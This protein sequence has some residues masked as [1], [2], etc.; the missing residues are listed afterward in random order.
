MPL[1]RDLHWE[2][3]LC[4]YICLTANEDMFP[5]PPFPLSP[6]PKNLEIDFLTFGAAL[7]SFKQLCAT[8]NTGNRLLSAFSKTVRS[9]R[10]YGDS[11]FIYGLRVGV[12]STPY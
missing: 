12:T 4:V 2:S 6:L 9:G 7:G 11:C 5:Y 1:I 10:S 3:C 8:D